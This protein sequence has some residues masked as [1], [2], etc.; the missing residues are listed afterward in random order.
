MMP[1][2][3]RE[4]QLPHAVKY[5]QDRWA[6]KNQTHLF[7]ISVSGQM[8]PIRCLMPFG[9]LLQV[10]HSHSGTSHTHARTL[11]RREKEQ[12]GSTP[13]RSHPLQITICTRHLRTELSSWREN[14]QTETG[15]VGKMR[16]AA[17]WM[18]SGLL[19]WL[20]ELP[21]RHRSLFNLRGTA[22]KALL[23]RAASSYMK[24]GHFHTQHSLLLRHF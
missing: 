8:E 7:W 13:G 10:A 1:A 3:N 12:K 18:L 4:A 9:Y 21:Y 20:P 23:T 14:K 15:R 24:H 5:T 19:D 16:S 2:A 6:D 11:R 22:A 17:V